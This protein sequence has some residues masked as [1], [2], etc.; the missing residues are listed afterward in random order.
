MERYIT[1]EELGTMIRTSFFA[2][3][4]ICL[5]LGHAKADNFT[6]S[7]TNDAGNVSGTVTGEIFG[8]INDGATHPATSVVINSYPPALNPF[9]TNLTLTTW[10][11]INANQFIESSGLITFADFGARDV[12]TVCTVQCV[13]NIEFVPP[14][15][16]F[17]GISVLDTSGHRFT[18][19]DASPTFSPTPSVP[20]P[21]PVYLLLTVLGVV[22]IVARRRHVQGLAVGPPE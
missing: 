19:T 6:F 20:E 22:A 5:S 9:D 16:N 13:A 3:A 2:F 17:T 14:G 4:L 1:W 21:S 8:L 18:A 7:F 11:T 10:G 12:T 15:S